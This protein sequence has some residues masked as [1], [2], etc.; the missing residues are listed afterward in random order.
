MV[1]EPLSVSNLTMISHELKELGD[2]LQS[3]LRIEISGLLHELAARDTAVLQQFET[4]VARQFQLELQS[5]NGQAA[6]R[7]LSPLPQ[8]VDTAAVDCL[9]SSPST[10]PTRGMGD[11]VLVAS[12][13]PCNPGT[14]SYTGTV[15]GSGGGGKKRVG[16]KRVKGLGPD[17]EL[18]PHLPCQGRCGGFDHARGTLHSAPAGLSMSM[19]ASHRAPSENNDTYLPSPP[20][21]PS[22]L[23]LHGVTGFRHGRPKGMARRPP[24]LPPI[25][26]TMADLP[27]SVSETRRPSAPDE[28]EE[29]DDEGEETAQADHAAGGRAVNRDHAIDGGAGG[30]GHETGV[31]TDVEQ[32]RKLGL[33]IDTTLASPDLSDEASNAMADNTDN[34][35]RALKKT[36]RTLSFGS[37][38][39]DSNLM[40]RDPL[41]YGAGRRSKGVIARVVVSEYFDYLIGFVLICN[42]ATIGWQVDHMAQ[43]YTEDVP[44]HFQVFEVFFCGAFVV[45]LLARIFVFRTSLFTMP[46]W[47]WN[48]FDA[49]VICL[50]VAEVVTAFAIGHSPEA[51][52]GVGL[53]RTV[54]L[55]RIVRLVRMVR[56]IPELKSMV[57]LIAA[58][59]WSFFW[60]VV[61]LLLLMF[62]VAVYFTEL[63][64]DYRRET[65]NQG[66]LLVDDGGEPQTL[67]ELLTEQWGSISASVLSLYQAILGGVDWKTITDPVSEYVSSTTIPIF[68]IYI[69]FATLVML[70]LVTG[71]FVEGA[72]RIIREDRDAEL[73]RQVRKMFAMTDNDDDRELSWEEF[74]GHIND[75]RMNE[76][77]KAVDL[78]RQDARDLFRLLDNDSSGSL[79]AEEFVQGCIRLR[80]PARSVDLMTMIYNYKNS[81]VK[82][83]DHAAMMDSMLATISEGLN[84]LLVINGAAP[85]RGRSF[86]LG[87]Q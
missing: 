12:G 49:F 54:R 1:A 55:G 5:P 59:M 14:L 62:G 10:P 39:A 6:S 42:T 44:F 74:E 61:L 24:P 9:P 21:G 83:M 23:P 4:T 60:T 66:R 63:V 29:E 17:M 3:S 50:Q 22:P 78:S 69:A 57:Y 33:G 67:E 79:S 20:P 71:V 28:S 16:P 27:G 31:S 35:P 7:A 58:S 46:G 52:D 53:L 37:P 86:S 87:T 18:A 70:N 45:E 77:F 68:C 64:S 56:L 15:V 26:H 41:S 38:M 51:L 85:I 73:V 36:G 30:I 32:L 25:P 80:G 40:S 75:K 19:A 48:V 81:T 8:Q 43:N 47:V 13:P 72:Q 76:Y 11:H 34:K 65:F 82:W 84:N 2:R